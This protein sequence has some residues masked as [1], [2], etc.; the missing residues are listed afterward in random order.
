MQRIV[1]CMD[2][3]SAYRVGHAGVPELSHWPSGEL[4]PAQRREALG[5]PVPGRAPAIP[6]RVLP[7]VAAPAWGSLGP[8]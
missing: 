3:L 5:R 1:D 7:L 8:V 2:S 4:T 6:T